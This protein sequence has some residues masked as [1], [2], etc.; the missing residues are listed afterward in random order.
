MLKRHWL[1]PGPLGLIVV[2]SFVW[3]MASWSGAY[4][5]HQRNAN[6]QNTPYPV[7]KVPDPSTFWV[8][9]AASVQTYERVCAYP[10]DRDQ[11][12][13]CQ[14]WKSAEA[15]QAVA[16]YTLVSLIVGLCGLLGLWYSI[17]LSNRATNA[18][19]QATRAAVRSAEAAEKAYMFD[20]RPLFLISELALGNL[21]PDLLSSQN[22]PFLYRFKNH[23]KGLGWITRVHIWAITANPGIDPV[24]SPELK[25]AA[26]DW[27]VAPDQ[28]WGTIELSDKQ[29]F[30]LPSADC[31]SII[32]G[33]LVFYM[34]GILQYAGTTD[35]AVIYEYQF[36]HQFLPDQGR[37][38][39]VAHPFNRYT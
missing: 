5:E 12:D 22:V 25:T 1:K 17:K 37:F 9:R 19:T 21:E 13:L 31:L 3:L 6:E 15:A 39:P 35:R 20:N 33:K 28:W 16:N 23:G 24:I 7:G 8:G 18:A 11:A 30:T 4:Y 27:P 32:D 34:A 29:V 26:P 36:V 38:V 2:I 14:Q 10:I